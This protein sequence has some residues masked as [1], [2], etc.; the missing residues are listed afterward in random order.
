M[1]TDDPFFDAD[2]DDS[3]RTVIR[4]M[5]G[6]RRPGGGAATPRAEPPPMQPRAPVPPPGRYDVDRGLNPLVTAAAPLLSLLGK[7]RNAPSHP[8]VNSL[9]RRMEEELRLFESR[10]ASGGIDQESIFAARYALCTVIDETVLNTPWGS[11]S[12]WSTESLLILFHKEAWGGEKFFQM[13]E[14][15]LKDP[16]RFLEML[17]L[18]YICLSMG[19]EG[20]YR[21]IEGGNRTL[22][23][24][25]DSVYRTIR[26]Q[27][28]EYEQDL[29]VHWRGEQLGDNTL[30]HYIPLWVVAALSGVLLLST[31]LVFSYFIN[32]TSAPVFKDV[33]AVGREVPPEID[34]APP[35][36]PPVKDDL[37]DRVS[38][39]LEPEVRE[40][41]VELIN[42]DSDV[43]IRLRNKGL[44]G[45]GSDQVKSG[46]RPLLQRIAE[47]LAANVDDPILVA[48]HSDNI[49]IH[50]LRFPS[51][52]HLSMGRAESVAEI[53]RQDAAIKGEIVA[54]GR[55]DNEP[56]V[57]NDSSENRARNRRV[58]IILEK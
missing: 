9:R 25:R 52:W 46:F 38:G 1:T 47:A 57:P 29:S 5:P 26:M 22:E 15:M 8:D 39:F 32:D 35:P 30:R 24:I 36:P 17:E 21:I 44:F 54:D 56:L 23:Q 14:R 42:N 19:F 18:M 37:Y 53:L 49:P 48:G 50:T 12:P 41:L 31:F 27:R 20:K 45:S 51:N 40:G 43:V 6:G 11:S 10:A 58:E 3:D 16:G 55:A 34:S 28:G 4:P 13:L 2:G 33:Y 7:L